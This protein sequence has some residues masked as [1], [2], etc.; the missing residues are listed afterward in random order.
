MKEFWLNFVLWLG[1][2]TSMM[3]AGAGCIYIIATGDLES[4]LSYVLIFFGFVLFVAT[5]PAYILHTMGGLVPPPGT[6][7][8]F[9][10]RGAPLP[11][12]V[13]EGGYREVE[14][15]GRREVDA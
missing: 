7:G 5:V 4:G 3:L 8:L 15:S 12:E 1:G 2:I 14:T 11:E 9:G 13:E 10:I 6:V